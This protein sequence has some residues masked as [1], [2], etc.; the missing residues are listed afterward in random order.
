VRHAHGLR[1][2]LGTIGARAAGELF[3]SLET[4]GTSGDLSGAPRLVSQAQ[5]AAQR[6]RQAIEA[7]PF[8]RKAA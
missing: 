6:T 4:L 2:M 5:V 7:L 3:A 1:G 8:R